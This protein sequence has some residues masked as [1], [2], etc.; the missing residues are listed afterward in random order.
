MRVVCTIPNA[1]ENMSGIA[2]TRQPSGTLLSDEISEDQGARLLT[3]PGFSEVAAPVDVP[4]AP[5]VSAGVPSIDETDGEEADEEADVDEADIDGDDGEEPDD[6]V[7]A[8]PQRTASKKPSSR[9]K[10]KQR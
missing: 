3:I 10:K 2:F 6:T 7:D 5:I 1:S 9:S 4:P 8:P